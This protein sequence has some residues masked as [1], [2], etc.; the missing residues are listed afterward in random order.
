MIEY[1]ESSELDIVYPGDTLDF[2]FTFKNKD[3]SPLNIS[4]KTL[5]FTAKLNIDDETN[6]ETDIVHS[7][8]F[9]PSPDSIGGIGSM[10]IESKLT[11]ILVPGREMRYD[12]RL[13]DGDVVKTIDSGKF[14]VVQNITK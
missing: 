13:I 11:A 12:F 6:K 1:T 9:E 2:D 14:K 5:W 4:G 10:Q 3:G 7:K 8:V